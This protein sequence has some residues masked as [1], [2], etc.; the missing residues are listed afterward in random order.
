[1]EVFGFLVAAFGVVGATWTSAMVLFAWRKARR[2]K[3]S[4]QNIRDFMNRR[5]EPNGRRI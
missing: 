4:L 1:M 3:I 5:Y 2:T